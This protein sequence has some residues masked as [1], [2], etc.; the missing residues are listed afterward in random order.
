MILDYLKRLGELLLSRK[1]QLTVAGVA[2][3]YTVWESTP[4]TVETTL[5]F[6]SV[7]VVAVAA[8]VSAMGRVDAAKLAQPNADPD[9][10]VDQ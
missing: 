3:A 5:V 6:I 8:L 10:L 4:K 1:F 9:R 7:V 2:T